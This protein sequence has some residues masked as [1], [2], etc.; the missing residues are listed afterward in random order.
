MQSIGKI[1]KLQNYLN[2]NQVAERLGVSVKLL[3]KHRWE[4]KGLPYVKFGSRILD[5]EPEVVEY[6]L[7]HRIETGK[8]LF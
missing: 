8:N 7:N 5:A 3:R 6:L 4:S 1:N 2:E